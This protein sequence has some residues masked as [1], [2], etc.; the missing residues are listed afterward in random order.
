MQSQVTMDIFTFI[1]GSLI[2]SLTHTNQCVKH[3]VIALLVCQHCAT[4]WKYI[5]DKR[6]SFLISKNN[7]SNYV[8]LWVH[9][10]IYAYLEDQICLFVWKWGMDG[11]YCN[12]CGKTR[13]GERMICDWE[14]KKETDT[15]KDYESVQAE[16]SPLMKKEVDL[17]AYHL[18]LLFNCLGSQ[19]TGD[20]VAQILIAI[21]QIYVDQPMLE[22]Q[23]A[24]V[25][26]MYRSQYRTVWR[27]S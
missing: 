15:K 4:Y 17:E 3:K 24:S 6:S 25:W 1:V 26:P 9:V 27:A 2:D 22:D 16:G 20:D 7:W 11:L 12:K 8:C 10:C 23:E 5:Y 14:N 18:N 19:I 13:V 21:I